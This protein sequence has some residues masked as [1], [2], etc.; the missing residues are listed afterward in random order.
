MEFGEDF[1]NNTAGSW[2]RLLGNNTFSDIQKGIFLMLK[3]TSNGINNAGFVQI[4]HR[5]CKVVQLF[6]YKEQL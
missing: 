1:Q 3:D 5:S 4:H 6:G 2:V